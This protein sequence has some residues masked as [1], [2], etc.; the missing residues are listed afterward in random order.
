MY[1]Y[2]LEISFTFPLNTFGKISTT[3]KTLC[4]FYG[5]TTEPSNALYCV[6]MF[7]TLIHTGLCVC[8]CVCVCVI[9]FSQMDE[10]IHASEKGCNEISKIVASSLWSSKP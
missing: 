2:T 8:V 7:T 5:I 1:V 4:D 10:E 6:E 9:E 3:K